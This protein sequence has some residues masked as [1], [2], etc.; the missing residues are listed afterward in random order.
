[1]FSVFKSSILPSMR[2]TGL[3]PST[4]WDGSWSYIHTC[5]PSG[6]EEGEEDKAIDLADREFHASL[7][8]LKQ[9]LYFGDL[10]YLVYFFIYSSWCLSLVYIFT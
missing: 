6:R 1:M 3:R 9:R 2:S 4:P 5:V 8:Y 7:D 10:S